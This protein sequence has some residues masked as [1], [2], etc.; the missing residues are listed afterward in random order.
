[1]RKRIG[2][3]KQVSHSS[4]PN[5]NRPDTLTR[6]ATDPISDKFRLH[7]LLPSKCTLC[8]LVL[9]AVYVTIPITLRLSHGLQS[10]IIYVNFIPLPFTG[11]LSHPSEFNLRNTRHQC[12]E[13][14]D[15][16]SVCFWHVLPIK[17]STMSPSTELFPSYLSDGLPI[18]IYG[19]GNTGSRAVYHRVELYKLL[20]RKNFHVIAFDYRGFGDSGG[21]AT[22][23]GLS[24]DMFLMWNWTVSRAPKS[25]IIIFGH[26]LG[27]APTAQVAGLLGNHSEYLHV[28]VCQLL[29]FNELS[30]AFMLKIFIFNQVKCSVSI[31]F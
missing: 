7:H 30:F 5:G 13:Q 4:Q 6:I 15:G 23:F 21:I 12:I 16:A 27:C 10:K 2:K 25:K 29:N 14:F 20:A 26:S 24:E 1:M 22:E 17:Y 3:A 8:L 31:I 11:N 18:I 9:V 28:D 19:H